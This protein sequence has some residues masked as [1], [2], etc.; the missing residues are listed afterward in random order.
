M[1]CVIWGLGACETNDESQ[2]KTKASDCKID[3]T[4][5]LL[6]TLCIQKVM[7]PVLSSPGCLSA[8]PSH[9]LGNETYT[10]L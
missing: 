5:Q 1:G 8:S 3:H 9:I 2:G 4:S 10:L 7:G 6:H